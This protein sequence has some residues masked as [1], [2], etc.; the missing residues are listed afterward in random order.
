V[1]N[2][3]SGRWNTG[4]VV[5]V[6]DGGTSVGSYTEIPLVAVLGHYTA[7]LTRCRWIRYSPAGSK[8]G[9]GR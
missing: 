5:G 3:G 9:V 2:I 7:D 4:G 1:W 6:D 8:S